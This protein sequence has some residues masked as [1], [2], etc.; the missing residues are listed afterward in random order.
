MSSAGYA[1]F[2][3]HMGSGWFAVKEILDL[4]E[5]LSACAAD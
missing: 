5:L 3:P 2:Q 1:T 4:A